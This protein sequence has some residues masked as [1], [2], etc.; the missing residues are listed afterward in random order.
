MIWEH[1]QLPLH[2]SLGITGMWTSAVLCLFV[3]WPFFL[4]FK[5]LFIR[6]RQTDRQAEGVAE[7]EGEVGSPWSRESDVG[8]D[9]RTLGS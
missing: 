6:E 9:P 4:S 7:G 8:L 2:F 5:D 1:L 3:S